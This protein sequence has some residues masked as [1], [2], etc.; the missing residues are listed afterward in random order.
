VTKCTDATDDHREGSSK[1][2]GNITTLFSIVYT[3]A[4]ESLTQRETMTNEGSTH[5]LLTVHKLGMHGGRITTQP[6]QNGWLSPRT[7]LQGIHNGQSQRFEARRSGPGLEEV[8]GSKP[9]ALGTQ[10][11]SFCVVDSHR[12]GGARVESTAHG[13]QKPLASQHAM[14]VPFLIVGLILQIVGHGWQI[15]GQI[16]LINGLPGSTHMAYWSF[17][18]SFT[19]TI[20]SCA[21]DQEPSA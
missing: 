1:G 21:N 8:L 18:M 9:G 3:P 14:T 16:L 10:L 20:K 17:T 7:S 15:V 11:P 19:P 4:R 12:P 5:V 2:I 6:R 13:H